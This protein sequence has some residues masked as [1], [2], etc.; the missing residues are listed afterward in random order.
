MA[1]TARINKSKMLGSARTQTKT[2]ENTPKVNFGKYDPEAKLRATGKRVTAEHNNE[3][4]KAVNGKTIREALATGLY[5][6]S[7]IVYDIER[8]K[9]L[10]IA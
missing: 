10:E 6:M 7:G 3:R 4:V 8:V 5:T 1:T 2:A 9:T